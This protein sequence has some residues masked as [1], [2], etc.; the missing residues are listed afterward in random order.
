[1]FR[2][3]DKGIGSSSAGARYGWR[4]GFLRSD[5]HDDAVSISGRNDRFLGGVERTG[6]GNDRSRS[7]AGM[8][9]KKSK[10]NGNNNSN[11][12]NKATATVDRLFVF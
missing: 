6:N 7:P 4:S 2:K 11:G 3:I 1:M 9:S 12:N 8:T 10:C 5:A